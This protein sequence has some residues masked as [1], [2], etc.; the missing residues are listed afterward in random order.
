MVSSFSPWLYVKSFVLKADVTVEW[1]KDSAH[2]KK[3]IISI[4]QCLKQIQYINVKNDGDIRI[5]CKNRHLPLSE[6]LFSEIYINS[7]FHRFLL[8]GSFL[9]NNK[10]HLYKM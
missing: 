8:Y 10:W 6:Y 2:F 9:Q 5:G 3:H 1:V 4:K 7:K